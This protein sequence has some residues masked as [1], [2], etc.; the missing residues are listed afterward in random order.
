LTA[1]DS[2]LKVPT[3]MRTSQM[4]STRLASPTWAIVCPAF[5]S[6]VDSYPGHLPGR[7]STDQEGIP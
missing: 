7:E 2:D 5:A 1:V 3:M 6:K 4:R